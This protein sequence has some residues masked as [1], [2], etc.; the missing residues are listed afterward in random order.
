VS[1]LLA[2]AQPPPP[3]PL[4]APLVGPGPTTTYLQ[5]YRDRQDAL[6]GEYA[7]LYV[8]YVVNARRTPQEL[9]D[10]LLSLSEVVP[11]AF[12]ALVVDDDGVC[13]TRTLHRVQ[14]YQSHPVTTSIWDGRAFAF[15]GDVLP[16]NHIDM[17][18][19]PADPFALV[20]ESVLPTVTHTTALLAAHPHQ[21]HILP[22]PAG[23]QDTEQLNARYFVQ[24]PQ[25]YLPLLLTRRLTPRELWEQVV[26]AIIADNRQQACEVFVTWARVA[27]VLRP[28]PA[29]PANFLPPANCLGQ[30]RAHLA[31]AAVDEALQQHR[32]SLLTQDLPALD[33]QRL[34]QSDQV[35]AVL[36]AL[37]QDRAAERA[38]DAATA[39]AAK[40]PKLP[41]EA[42]PLTVPVWMLA[43]GVSSERHLPPLYHHWAQAAKGER[44]A[45]FVRL[46]EQRAAEAG[47][48]T[49]IV[50]V[51]SKE[52]LETVLFGK[53]AP[54]VYE[55]DDLR[56]G[57]QPFSCGYVL[58]TR[59]GIVESRAA[60]YDLMLAGLAAPTMEEQAQLSTKEVPFPATS[61]AAG[62]QL[63]GC[64]LVLDVVLGKD[65][66]LAQAYRT[67]CTLDWPQMEAVLNVSAVY[68]PN[69]EANVLPPILRWV[70]IQVI[71]VSWQANLG[72][73]SVTLA[74][75]G[76]YS[77]FATAP[78]FTPLSI[79]S[80]IRHG[81]SWTFFEMWG[82]HSP[83]STI[84]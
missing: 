77:T 26:Q 59:G 75:P 80:N 67:L 15:C 66:L 51:V 33:P 73:C 62:I 4:G 32:W 46:L 10:R 34:S 37:R 24:I 61:Y 8:P 35:L 76:S 41:S 14:R 49:T 43:C 52:L 16:G 5:L 17:V 12:L 1:A 19:F 81:P 63:R 58:D 53:L 39:A 54:A 6:G 64:S 45:V 18:E 42:F 74:G 70:Q 38:A 60:S 47:A 25:A 9:R 48:A 31:P 2:M 7:P 36:A 78:A 3:A 72:A 29:D 57:L 68:D 20:G 56:L 71:L 30:A 11:K 65:N 44:R 83:C 50:P 40:Q 27:L 84:N 13:R 23:A 69:L 79:H 21:G 55:A 82:P 28:D 22:L